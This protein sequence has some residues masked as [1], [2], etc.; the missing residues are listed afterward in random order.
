MLVSTGRFDRALPLLAPTAAAAKTGGNAY[1]R[2]LVRRLSYCTYARLGRTEQAAAIL[3]EVLQNAKDANAATI[4]GLV[5]A[6]NY[7][8]AEK[9]LVGALAD[10]AFQEDMVRQLQPVS[11][12]S[13]D[14]SVWA[15]GWGELRARPAVAEAYLKYRRDMPEAFL[16]R[17]VEG[18]S[19]GA[20]ATDGS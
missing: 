13:D 10:A 11:L 2:Q 8:Q 12:T 18:G 4:D 6:G 17:A 15:K 1:A 14:P 5:C 19:P 3:P 7:E 9:V 20:A 16:V